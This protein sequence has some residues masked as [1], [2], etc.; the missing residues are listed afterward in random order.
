MMSVFFESLVLPMTLQYHS[1]SV[2]KPRDCT[3]TFQVLNGSTVIVEFE[4]IGFKVNDD[5]DWPVDGFF[6]LSFKS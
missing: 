2:G 5:R 6:I 3:K 1:M 4:F